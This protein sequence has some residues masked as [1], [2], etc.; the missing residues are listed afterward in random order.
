MKLTHVHT[1]ISHFPLL[2]KESRLRIR[3]LPRRGTHC[4]SIAATEQLLPCRE[5]ELFVVKIIRNSLWETELWVLK[6][7][8]YIVTTLLRRI[9]REHTKNSQRT[10]LMSFAVVYC[11]VLCM[12]TIITSHFLLCLWCQWCMMWYDVMWYVV[13][14]YFK[15]VRHSIGHQALTHGLPK[16]PNLRNFWP[17]FVCI[18]CMACPT[19]R[20]Y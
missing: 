13:I 10:G 4:F 16:A 5:I 18:V 9:K 11:I 1:Q 15:E 7:T 20:K 17:C 8:I 19:F 14:G 2:R 3:F 12:L 6:Q